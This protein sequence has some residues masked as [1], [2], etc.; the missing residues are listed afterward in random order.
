MSVDP[1]GR[2]QALSQAQ[3]ARKAKKAQQAGRTEKPSFKDQ[4]RDRDSGV[5]KDDRGAGDPRPGLDF[6]A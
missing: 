3:R 1:V 6:K 4:I 2:G 5:S